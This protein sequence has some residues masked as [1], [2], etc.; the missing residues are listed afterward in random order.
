MII[1]NK[2]ILILGKPGEGKT[3]LAHFIASNYKRIYSNVNFLDDKWNVVNEH[4]KNIEDLKEI[5]FSPEKWVIVLDEWGVNINARRSSSDDNRVYGELGMLWRKLNADIIICA[6][7]GRM[8]DVY[9][10]ELANYIFEMHAWFEKK[11]YL[12]FEAKIYSNGGDTIIKVARFDLFEWVRLTWF[13]YNTLEQSR[14]KWKERNPVENVQKNEI[15]KLKNTA[16]IESDFFW[17]PFSLPSSP[18]F[19]DNSSEIVWGYT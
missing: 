6:Q 5:W 1:K 12:M 13:T 3:F 9:F 15:R 18:L 11:D 14:I 10:R 8:I 2:I 16:K 17:T 7:L 4:I 19:T